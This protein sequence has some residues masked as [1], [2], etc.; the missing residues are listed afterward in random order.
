ML[1]VWC[2]A[3]REEYVKRALKTDYHSPAKYRYVQEIFSE[4]IKFIFDTKTK[5]DYDEFYVVFFLFSRTI[6]PLSN[7][8][9]FSDAFKCPLGPPMNPVKKCPI[10]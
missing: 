10:W 1:Q 2:G 3:Y 6:G 5:L 4:K 8:K 9:A 7:L